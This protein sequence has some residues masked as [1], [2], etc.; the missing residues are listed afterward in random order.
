MR[1]HRQ[2]LIAGACAALLLPAAAAAD[3]PRCAPQRAARTA[4]VKQYQ[5][6]QIALLQA[7]KNLNRAHNDVAFAIKVI[8]GEQ[9]RVDTLT[10]QA[11]RIERNLC[12]ADGAIAWCATKRQHL[13]EI[14]ARLAMAQAVLT[15]DQA[16]LAE[17]QALIG[18]REDEL[19]AAQ[20]K[21]VADFAVLQS[22]IAAVDDC[23]ATK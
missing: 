5:A 19:A 23:K 14:R 21:R 15:R 20:A 3:P 10:L 12:R 18:Q 6:D 9:H 11:A 16:F 4:A 1:I 13:A 22:A 7:V 2:A 8:P 17:S